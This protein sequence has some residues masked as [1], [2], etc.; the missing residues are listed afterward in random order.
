[1]ERANNSDP[2][3]ITKLVYT[4]PQYRKQLREKY[5][6]ELERQLKIRS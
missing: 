6:E 2:Y 4:P 3:S 5:I 1:M